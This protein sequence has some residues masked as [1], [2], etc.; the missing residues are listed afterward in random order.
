MKKEKCKNCAH[1]IGHKEAGYPISGSAKL[2]FCKQVVESNIAMTEAGYSCSNY[3]ES[4]LKK[5]KKDGIN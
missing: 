3:L 4:K 5:D 2:G 1:W